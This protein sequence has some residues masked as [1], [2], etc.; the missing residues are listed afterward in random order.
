M[1]TLSKKLEYQERI[2]LRQERKMQRS[3]LKGIIVM[4]LL[5][6]ALIFWLNGC[7][8]LEQKCAERFPTEINSRT[9]I[10]IENKDTTLPEVRLYSVIDC[11]DFVAQIPEGKKVLLGEKDN[12]K[13]YGQRGKNNQLL[14]EAIKE[15]EN[16]RQS[17][18]QITN[19]NESKRIITPPV[20]KG[21]KESWFQRKIGPW[22]SLLAFVVFGG[23]SGYV[24]YWLYAAF[25][26]KQKQI[27][28]EDAKEQPGGVQ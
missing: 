11:P 8:S 7:K 19:N 22:I 20:P 23:L 1:K 6:T 16:I 12:V 9:E 27:E 25:R 26:R 24:G 14:L 10:R 13:L 5:L 21:E 15:K 4:T 3:Q 18:T 17:Q 2:R 28:K